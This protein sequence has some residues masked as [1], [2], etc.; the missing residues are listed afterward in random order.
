[1][2]E[3]VVTE[4][5]AGRSL[6]GAMSRRGDV[7]SQLYI[8]LIK[9]GETSGH[10]SAVLVMVARQSQGLFKVRRQL[11]SALIYPTII[12]SVVLAIYVTF[13]FVVMPGFEDMYRDFSHQ[14]PQLRIPLITQFALMLGRPSVVLFISVSSIGALLWLWFI[15]PRTER[16]RSIFL[17]LMWSLPILGRILLNYELSRNM[18]LLSILLRGAVPVLDALQIVGGSTPVRDL[19]AGFKGASDR[20]AEGCTLSASLEETG[21]FPKNISWRISLGEKGGYVPQ[22]VEDI[23]GLYQAWA[24][25]S[26]DKINAIIEPVLVVLSGGIIG[27]TVIAL[28]LPMIQLMEILSA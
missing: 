10:L 6:S 13:S 23:A 19:A 25:R 15:A 14:M 11:S 18:G 5:R 21:V 16:G 3:D 28:F 8:S 27:V 9:A 24:E 4:L 12:L 1:A 20:V 7:F 17:N 22:A 2:L 26:A